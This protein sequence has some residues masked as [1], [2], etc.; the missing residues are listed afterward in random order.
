MIHEPEDDDMPF[1]EKWFIPCATAI[2]MIFGAVVLVTLL[3]VWA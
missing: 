2:Y 3:G 1:C